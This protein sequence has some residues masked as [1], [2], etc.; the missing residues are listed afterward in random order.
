MLINSWSGGVFAATDGLFRNSKFHIK[1]GPIDV[2]NKEFERERRYTPRRVLIFS[3]KKGS[4]ELIIR[5]VLEGDQEEED[6][7]NSFL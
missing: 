5:L 6:D 2:L 1:T 7:F 3:K 4:D